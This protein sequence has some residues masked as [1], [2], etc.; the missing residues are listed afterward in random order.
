MIL[1]PANGYKMNN[2][3]LVDIILY[4]VMVF[5]GLMIHQYVIRN[6]LFKSK[7]AVLIVEII[8]II[9]LNATFLNIIYQSTKFE[10]NKLTI[11]YVIILAGLNIGY[12]A[13]KKFIDKEK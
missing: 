5:A 3:L 6:K 11:L 10:F 8:Q 13:I 7:K 12:F 2:M 1:C 4:F 9:F